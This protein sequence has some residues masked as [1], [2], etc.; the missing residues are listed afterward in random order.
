M[1]VEKKIK[2]F[3]QTK[4]CRVSEGVLLNT[5]KLSSATCFILFNIHDISFTNSRLLAKKSTDV[6]TK[7]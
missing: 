1:D 5:L 6:V 4:T 3:C 2:L 7:R